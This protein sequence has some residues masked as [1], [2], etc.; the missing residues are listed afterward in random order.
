MHEA[1]TPQF[2][3]NLWRQVFDSEVYQECFSPHEEK[4]WCYALPVTAEV[5]VN[6]ACSKSY[7]SVLSDDERTSVKTDVGAIVE[8]GQDKIWIDESRDIF[9]Y[10]YQTLVVIAKRRLT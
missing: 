8:Q 6:R 4:V 10:P 7:I 9:E 5:V 2:R 3:L 1:G